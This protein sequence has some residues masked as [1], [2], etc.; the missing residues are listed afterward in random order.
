MKN[1][2]VSFLLLF[3]V[4]LTGVI[5]YGCGDSYSDLN[6]KLSETSLVFDLDSQEESALTS[7]FTA[8]L[9]GLKSGMLPDLIPEIQDSNV[10]NVTVGKP[11]GNVSTITVTALGAGETTL[12]LKAKE[13]SKVKVDNIKI[14]VK[15]APESIAPQNKHFAVKK[16]EQLNLS[17]EDMIITTP[18]RVYPIVASFS[19]MP[20]PTQINSNIGI[21]ADRKA[22]LLALWNTDYG[23]INPRN[24]RVENNVLKVD[25]T[26]DTGIVQ[27]LA[28]VG[29]KECSFGILIYDNDLNLYSIIE[30]DGA[31]VVEKVTQY[32]ELEAIDD[33]STNYSIKLSTSGNG[34]QI[35]V[36]IPVGE[37]DNTEYDLSEI[38]D[39]SEILRVDPI[40]SV[41]DT[42]GGKRYRVYTLTA[43]S[44]GDTTI[45]LRANLKYGESTFVTIDI[46][47]SIIVIQDVDGV[48]LDS[49]SGILAENEDY[50]IQTQYQG[51][52]MG[53]E[54]RVSLTP[55]VEGVI[56]PMFAITEV[57][58]V[59]DSGEEEI[60]EDY[61][62]KVHIYTNAQNVVSTPNADNIFVEYL[63]NTT[64]PVYLKE[65]S[66]FYV[67]VTSDVTPQ[68]QF[69]I[70]VKATMS[71]PLGYTAG[72]T[73]IIPCRVVDAVK[74]LRVISSKKVELGVSEDADIN[75][76]KV[77]FV[78][79][80]MD[81]L[82]QFEFE[83]DNSII[84]IDINEDSRS[85]IT[86]EGADYGKLK[87]ELIVIS[88]GEGKTNLTIRALSGHSDIVECWCYLVVTES[89]FAIAVMEQYQSLLDTYTTGWKEDKLD[90]SMYVEQSSNKRVG[91]AYMVSNGAQSYKNFTYRATVEIKDE[92]LTNELNTRYLDS[93]HYFVFTPNISLRENKT[94][95]I[96]ITF[97]YY[98]MNSETHQWEMTSTTREVKVEVK[99]PL[100][101]LKWAEDSLDLLSVATKTQALY[102]ENELSA[103]NKELSTQTFIFG[104][105][106]SLKVNDLL[107]LLFETVE[108]ETEPGAVEEPD[109]GEGGEGGEEE[110]PSPTPSFT[111][112]NAVFVAV[113]SPL[114]VEYE[115]EAEP[116]EIVQIERG[117]YKYWKLTISLKKMPEA[118]D[119]DL[120]D[121]K[122][123]LVVSYKN[124]EY[125][126]LNCDIVPTEIE[127]VT[128]IEVTNCNEI[129]GNTGSLALKLKGEEKEEFTPIVNLFATDRNQNV[130]LNRYG[131]YID[132]EP[133]NNADKIIIM[134]RQA[135]KWIANKAGTVTVY[136]Y[137]LDRVKNV[138]GGVDDVD[139]SYFTGD[140]PWP[141]FIV[142]ITVCDG[143]SVY[144]YQIYTSQDFLDIETLGLDK[145][146]VLKASI[147]LTDSVN[148]S[149]FSGF[150]KFTGSLTSDEGNVYAINGLKNFTFVDEDI[151]Y[152]G[153]F[154]EIS[155]ISIKDIIFNFYSLQNA[156]L[157]TETSVA[158]LYYGALA[159]KISADVDSENTLIM[160]DNV[161]VEMVN[162]NKKCEIITSD[163]IVASVGSIAGVV[164]NSGEGKLELDNVK[165]EANFEVKCANL[166]L[167]GLFGVVSTKVSVASSSGKV[168]AIMLKVNSANH[169]TQSSIGGL[170]GELNG[171]LIDASVSGEIIAANFDN[172]G[173]V[174]GKNTGTLGRY[175]GAVGE[176]TTVIL[177]IK[178]GVMV[179]GYDNVGGIVGLNSGNLSNCYAI[180]YVYNSSDIY[181]IVRGKSNV[182]G[183]I[184]KSTGGTVGYSY[185]VSFKDR[186]NDLPFVKESEGSVGYHGDV[187]GEANVGG[188]VGN[189]SYTSYNSCF[190]NV[191]IQLLGV[192]KVGGLFGIFGADSAIQNF[193]A[194]CKILTLSDDSSV[195]VGQFAGA[196]VATSISKGYTY[197][198]TEE[199]EI[200]YLSFADVEFT[201][202]TVYYFGEEE[203]G[204]MKTYAGLKVLNFNA[205]TYWK[206]SIPE[207]NDGLPILV[208]ANGENLITIPVTRIDISFVASQPT[209]ISVYKNASNYDL[210]LV[211][212]I[213][214]ISNNEF[215]LN[216]LCDIVVQDI[217]SDSSIVVSSTNDS[218]I[219]VD[220]ETLV[221]KGAGYAMITLQSASNRYVYS[222]FEINVI[223]SAMIGV[224]VDSVLVKLDEDE[225]EYIVVSDN[226]TC[227]TFVEANETHTINGVFIVGG[228][229]VV[230]SNSGFKYDSV[231]NGIAPYYVGVE[232][233]TTVILSPYW[234]LRFGD[235]IYEYVVSGQ[236]GISVTLRPY[237][238][239]IYNISV[240]EST[241]DSGEFTQ[242]VV[243]VEN[244]KLGFEVNDNECVL[245][246]ANAQQ[247]VLDNGNLIIDY[248][249]T[250]STI[251]LNM[252]LSN[253]ARNIIKDRTY[254]FKF[255]FKNATNELNVIEECV[256]IVFKTA[257][258]NKLNLDFYTKGINSY[259]A[260]TEM[261]STSIAADQQGMLVIDVVHDYADFD[262]AIIT[263]VQ[264]KEYISL[265]QIVLE[266]Q[267]GTYVVHNLEN[268]NEEFLRVE[269]YSEWDSGHN[270]YSVFSGLMFVRTLLNSSLKEGQV[271]SLN[272]KLMKMGETDYVVT[273]KNLLL[274]V[275]FTSYAE[276]KLSPTYKTT[277]YP[278]NNVVGRGTVVDVLLS[279]EF[280]NCQLVDV[281]ILS[282]TASKLGSLSEVDDG[283]E[284]YYEIVGELRDVVLG[285]NDIQV[286]NNS[287]LKIYIGPNVSETTLTVKLEFMQI[288]VIDKLPFP[289]D[290][291]LELDIVDFC[292][293]GFEVENLD[294][295][296]PKALEDGVL[297]VVVNE[298]KPLIVKA[299]YFEPIDYATYTS[300]T[301]NPMSE[302]D[303]VDQINGIHAKVDSV[304]DLINKNPI[305][306]E[307]KWKFY[308]YNRGEYITLLVHD[309][310]DFSII[311]RAD[312]DTFDYYYK[313]K[314]INN[315][316]GLRLKAEFNFAYV[317]G[318]MVVGNAEVTGALA[319]QIN[320]QEC[321]FLVNITGGSI[322]NDMP[323][324]IT[325]A[326][327]LRQIKNGNY[328]LANDID[329]EENWA[330]LA[331]GDSKL[332]LDGNGYIISM[333]SLSHSANEANVG[334]FA[335]LGRDVFIK[336]LIVSVNY[337]RVDLQDL[338]NVNFG[339]IAGQND[340][341]LYN[342][343][344]VVVLNEIL[345]GDT[346]TS[347]NNDFSYVS[348][349]LDKINLS[350]ELGE[351]QYTQNKA[352]FYVLTSNETLANVGGLVGINNGY[353]T[354]CRVGRISE[355][356]LGATDKKSL[357]GINLFASG[358]V[359]GFVGVN[360]SSIS[361]SY[362]ANGLIVNYSSDTRATTGG[363]VATQNSGGKINS[364]YAQGAWQ[365][366][367]QP[368]SDIEGIFSQQSAGGFVHTCRGQ[369]TNSYASMRIYE[370]ASM[371]GFVYSLESQ[372]VLT[373]C[374]SSSLVDETQS[375]SGAF[376][377]A[378]T[379]GVLQYNSAAKL[380]NCFYYSALSNASE[381]I[382]S[383]Y[384]KAVLIEDWVD[385]YGSSFVGFA[386]GQKG[387][388]GTWNYDE[389][390]S[391]LGPQLTFA[392]KVYY[393]HRDVNNF[394]RYDESCL[395]GSSVNP[396]L[397]TNFNDENS[398]YSW[399]Y[400]FANNTKQEKVLVD[401]VETTI[402]YLADGV[403]ISLLRDITFNANTSSFD[404]QFR[405]KL[406]GNGYTLS[407]FG[408]NINLEGSKNFGLFNSIV[409]GEVHNFTIKVAS[410]GLTST[411]AD[412]IGVLAGEISSGAN[413]FGSIPSFIE[414]VN[415]VGSSSLN[416][417]G[418]LGG[419]AG[420]V[421]GDCYIQCVNVSDLT[422]SS[423]S[424]L[425][426]V[427]G[428]IGKLD[429]T[430]AASNTL[431]RIYG[432]TASG[433]MKLTAKVVGGLIG[434]A[435]INSEIDNVSF[436]VS[437]SSQS[438][439]IPSMNNSTVGGVVGELQGKLTRA[440]IGD[441]IFA[442]QQRDNLATQV[443][444][445]LGNAN[446][447]KLDGIT[448]VDIG[449]LV[450]FSSGVIEYSYVRINLPSIAGA[451]IG[452]A[453]GAKLNQVYI[454]G[455]FYD[456]SAISA[457]REKATGSVS[458]AI[459][460]V[461]LSGATLT[462]YFN[463]GTSYFAN[464]ATEKWNK[465][466][467]FPVLEHSYAYVKTNVG[468][469][470]ELV[471]AL[472][473]AN[474][475]TL[476]RITQDITINADSWLKTGESGSYTYYKNILSYINKDGF[477]RDSLSAKIDGTI[478]TGGNS[479]RNAVITINGLTSEQFS[480]FFGI[481]ED[482]QLTNV[483]FIFNSSSFN[484]EFS[485]LAQSCKDSI[486]KNINVNFNTLNVSSNTFGG[487]CATANN[488]KFDS[489]TMIG[490]LNINYNNAAKIGGLVGNCDGSYVTFDNIDLKGLELRAT[491]SNG[492][493]NKDVILG[494]FV[495]N[496]SLTSVRVAN[497][498]FAK[499]VQI[500]S[501]Y[502]GASV[503]VGGF[504]GQAGQQL[505]VTNI[506][507]TDYNSKV[508]VIGNLSS[509]S[510]LH[511]GGVAGQFNGKTDKSNVDV[512]VEINLSGSTVS[513]L[514]VGGIAGWIQYGYVNRGH[515]IIDN[516]RYLGSITVN[517]GNINTL[518]LGGIVGRFELESGLGI[519]SLE[520]G[521]IMRD[522]SS[523][524]TITL[525]NN[526][527]ANAYIG[528]LVGMANY[529][530]T[531]M[532]CVFDKFAFNSNMI[533]QVSNCTDKLYVG[534]LVGLSYAKI[535]NSSSTG[536]IN[537]QIGGVG[538]KFVGG[539]S[540]N[541]QALH[542]ANQSS[543]AFLDNGSTS[544]NTKITYAN[545]ESSFDN[546]K[547]VDKIY[548]S[549]SSERTQQIPGEKELTKDEITD[550]GLDY[551]FDLIDEDV[552][553]NVKVYLS[554]TQL[555][556]VVEGTIAV[557]RVN[558][559]GD[560]TIALKANIKNVTCDITSSVLRFGS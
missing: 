37:D 9:S 422:I 336:N 472:K 139:L 184:G 274:N 471:E 144:P 242:I 348:S 464:F 86:E 243:Q 280:R 391:F 416:G 272:V 425:G 399:N 369:I 58:K 53:A 321:D 531:N 301:V 173:G 27:I 446:L 470:D 108:T 436:I 292:V 501:D 295:G 503:H 8:T 413:S 208:N 133:E 440:Y 4:L 395:P 32:D 508:K 48:A 258:V 339:F 61:K 498:K 450:G 249:K 25:E 326:E 341:I 517:V 550:L 361:N 506:S 427:G 325:T 334:L 538:A 445:V 1:R 251:T 166:M 255:T 456:S 308:E 188:L 433:T 300:L 196:L 338:S 79:D 374:Y 466:V 363:F 533:I 303:Y 189:S 323:T 510:A 155:A 82:A 297:P 93:N 337:N 126:S 403:Y 17:V 265:Q 476:I 260:G 50:P 277:Y 408:Y 465:S 486:F 111:L 286:L 352:N 559:T 368:R 161:T 63:V 438:E 426:V 453:D 10:A 412:N 78:A 219:S 41:F 350:Y 502:N 495:G 284:C 527:C 311:K 373:N 377:G 312:S 124:D 15:K 347:E 94:C 220:G 54:F 125:S 461:I 289:F 192:S 218:V 522:I 558:N 389:S 92:G 253:D 168:N 101:E 376:I 488:A 375:N 203:L 557:K 526:T 185:V 225:G 112:E 530:E 504:I 380:Q 83:Y 96:I 537:T 462:D 384:T 442:Q 315:V 177:P 360:N 478:K 154:K 345:A 100:V 278:N 52:M 113:I 362:F 238:K 121:G 156:D 268:S 382:Q 310:T 520:L 34:N 314:G 241:P 489:I 131:F 383:V 157:S 236:K 12:T 115:G 186:I 170:V 240:T 388:E 305:N 459:D 270:T 529:D 552:K 544:L 333:K 164:T 294:N 198:F 229:D 30:E 414:N 447:F 141:C 263:P 215:D 451:F 392:N 24:V 306:D 281:D 98:Q 2:Y 494:G 555:R 159:G 97:S 539:I 524:G 227:S 122:I 351:E 370:G 507:V 307:V 193:Y 120:I 381:S 387:M 417:S 435:G 428:V 107:C 393:S 355:E 349:V 46:N 560:L 20:T 211:V 147:D 468:T 499:L 26:A 491:A 212:D 72:Q 103:Y 19:I 74:S 365:E 483:D 492:A 553:P 257:G 47:Y 201:D 493:Q 283:N 329:L 151:E 371:G 534:G 353:I 167:G 521:T 163:G 114:L 202:T 535:Q 455:Q 542:S 85:R 135:N 424:D 273:E 55:E 132:N 45:V 275:D 551:F 509:L 65:G 366:E 191:N 409:G 545:V 49:R 223:N 364:C 279:G 117:R 340:G 419:L 528:G 454:V 357:Q 222:S 179:V 175:S 84:E 322:V 70:K 296:V 137:P 33:G 407:N 267:S 418:T 490:T 129:E 390:R 22:E 252:C 233:V 228:N 385:I 290:A 398:F 532:F 38:S 199:N 444:G 282:G 328:I 264:N 16:G 250:G 123:K 81:D 181:T 548:V 331:L 110:T 89:D 541:Q 299:N 404:T 343:E 474:G 57:F 213:S 60:I 13:Y 421:G 518:S 128:E 14:V 317:S 443:S 172:V 448:Y 536:S 439:L 452:E 396:I 327:E 432:L 320:K 221:I 256:D 261:P 497:S 158:T 410:F 160:F 342:C 152:V 304:V 234:N 458:E 525:Q 6:I 102:P 176:A 197:V 332:T 209:G 43:L 437:Q 226:Y 516:T 246:G 35:R 237:L 276:L 397:I 216:S 149:R 473:N 423:S 143:S 378:N 479:V 266:N 104:A 105:D 405:G 136:V 36:G 205:T 505:Y 514:N 487:L 62:G 262:Y 356:N 540:G 109:A 71:T 40:S 484:G 287:V 415:I 481:V 354:N 21:S 180:S 59:D 547:D 420:R 210:G 200:S 463:N 80:T 512:N 146:Y 546:L 118:S 394:N 372:A 429:L 23:E 269:K 482:L 293:T 66:K 182:G 313:I 367:S 259:L 91:I 73:L 430:V 39:Y 431:P 119:F 511:V 18:N 316:E 519:D 11:N 145:Y 7:S 500:E 171:E 457:G 469:L 214:Q 140:A 29:N 95:V 477:V 386:F 271:V 187:I 130:T 51:S 69:K 406:Y 460:V 5:F 401:Y 190:A 148:F 400:V 3:V 56:I 285:E 224:N 543:I 288:G 449:G 402:T 379:D 475:D 87:V 28:Q 346:F 485:L 169:N 515:T 523:T 88:T 298:Q 90:V 358:N 64:T 217:G 178:S 31:Q 302:S 319:T 467:L 204:Q 44:S 134:D 174:V 142:N 206:T 556:I 76:Q 247:F 194:N 106:A 232:S 309:Y 99:A 165:S 554:T 441:E 496:A 245:S 434:T 231:K 77:I 138:E 549:E 480:S 318:E 153:L 116:E 248:T 162:L 42:I 359:G 183:V 150:G 344:V 254:T 291:T 68:T 127:P 207:Y 67:T 75:Q 513:T 335:T 195:K 411:T 324:P 239:T 244:A 330:P 235:E 230:Y